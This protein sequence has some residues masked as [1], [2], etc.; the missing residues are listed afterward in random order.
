MI[1]DGNARVGKPF[2]IN[3][4]D[5]IFQNTQ[6]SQTIGTIFYDKEEFEIKFLKNKEKKQKNHVFRHFSSWLD[7]YI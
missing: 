6:Y 1:F 2:P 5:K 3:G 4:L 7:K